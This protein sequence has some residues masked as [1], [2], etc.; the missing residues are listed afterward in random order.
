MTTVPVS[1]YV[2]Q[3]ELIE[4][5]IK[6]QEYRND[7]TMNERCCRFKKLVHDDDDTNLVY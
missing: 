2:Y 5:D 6:T 3:H 4:S 1:S 7:N